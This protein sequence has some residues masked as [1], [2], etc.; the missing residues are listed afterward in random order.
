MKPDEHPRRYRLADGPLSSLYAPSQSLSSF[1][2]ASVMM[3]CAPRPAYSSAPYVI[4]EDWIARNTRH[5]ALFCVH[6]DVLHFL[7]RLV[8]FY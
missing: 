3:C 2:A 8:S 5:S 7:T 1:S 4:L 6:I